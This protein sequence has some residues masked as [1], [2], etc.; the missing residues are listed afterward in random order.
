MVYRKTIITPALT[1]EGSPLLSDLSV[2]NGLVYFLEIMF[3]SG[4]EGLL[5]VQI[6]DGSFPLWPST[7]GESF[8]GDDIYLKYDDLY[9]KEKEPFSLRVVT[10]NDDDMY[11]HKV[12]VGVGL[13]GKDIFKARFLPSLMYKEFEDVYT[14]ILKQQEEKKLAI[15][16]APFFPITQGV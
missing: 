7:P 1:T 11:Q 9:I 10:W 6:Y 13:V 15:L 14:R 8:M 3:P 16:K 2:T 12:V 4:S 5:H